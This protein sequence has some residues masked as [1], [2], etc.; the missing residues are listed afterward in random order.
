MHAINA[1]IL[2]RK[3][4]AGKQCCITRENLLLQ[5]ARAESKKQLGPQCKSISQPNQ[6]HCIELD[7]K[8]KR[9]PPTLL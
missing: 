8:R 1:Y 3:L 2:C 7:T 4:S 6:P 9:N 5:K